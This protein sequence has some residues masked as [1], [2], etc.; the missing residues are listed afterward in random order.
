MNLQQLRYVIAIAES[1]SMN[2]VA[3]TRF[4]SQSSVSVAVKELEQ[5]LGITIFKR[6]PKGI[7]VTREGV[8]FLGYAR[9]VI[10]QADLLAGRYTDPKNAHQ[11]GLSISSQHY[12]FVVRAFTSFVRTQH[13]EFFNFT[14]RETRTNDIIQD[15]AHFRADIGILFTS[16]YNERALRSRFD[17]NNLKFTSLHK[18]TPHVFVHKDH[19]LASFKSIKISQLQNWPRYT[20]EQGTQSSLYLS[21]EPFAYIAHPQNV[22]VSDRG[23]MT[24]LLANYNGFLISSGILSDEMSTL[25]K[26]IP[27]QT[28]ELMNIG[29]ITHAQRKLS[30]AAQLFI[31]KLK[32]LITEAELA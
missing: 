28:D 10:E 23:T 17:D 7:G 32:E 8:E 3:K 14:L 11:Q 13:N 4:I 20:F 16:A 19:P 12:A 6:S 27:L 24:S 5:E 2:S 9:Q 31:E 25:I 15:V 29:Y 18:A 1:G 26:S 22:V 30:D 21:E